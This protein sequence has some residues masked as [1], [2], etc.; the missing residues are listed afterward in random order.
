MDL[1]WYICGIAGLVSIFLKK[2]NRRREQY[3][4]KENIN[5]QLI[6]LRKKIEE[7]GT[8]SIKLY[9][10]QPF[11]EEFKTFLENVYEKIDG[12]NCNKIAFDKNLKYDEYKIFCVTENDSKNIV[13]SSRVVC[14]H[15]YIFRNKID[16]ESFSCMSYVFINERY[17]GRFEIARDTTNVDKPNYDLDNDWRADGHV[18]M[19]HGLLNLYFSDYLKDDIAKINRDIQRKKSEEEL[20]R[21]ERD[22]N[23][24]M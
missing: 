5:N 17:P 13:Y 3:K 16:F 15:K 23:I 6:E 8:E 11:F 9:E 2:K 12:H 19:S 18:M 4:L 14:D 21:K 1:V 7:K 22:K 20:Y 24:P 10:S